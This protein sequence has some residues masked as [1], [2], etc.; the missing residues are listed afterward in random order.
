MNLEAYQLNLMIAIDRARAS[1]YHH[2]AAAL[3]EL[4]RRS[5]IQSRPS[6]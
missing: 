1:G 5:L 2:F 3:V 4:L 6:L